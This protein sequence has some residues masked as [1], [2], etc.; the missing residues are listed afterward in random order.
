MSTVCM[1]ML[2]GMCRFKFY[3]KKRKGIY[4]NMRGSYFLSRYECIPQGVL[5]QQSK[6]TQNSNKSPLINKATST[7]FFLLLPRMF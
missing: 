4:G 7:H 3:P 2:T 5:P 1:L 6:Q